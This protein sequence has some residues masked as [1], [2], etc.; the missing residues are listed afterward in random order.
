MI[1]C[2]RSEHRRIQMNYDL[3]EVRFKKYASL[4]MYPKDWFGRLASD[5]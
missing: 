5:K 2:S 3:I 4:H 1:I